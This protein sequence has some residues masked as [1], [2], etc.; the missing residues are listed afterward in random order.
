MQ[1]LNRNGSYVERR[2]MYIEYR[3][4]VIKGSIP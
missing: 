4:H 2:K 1:N 3:K